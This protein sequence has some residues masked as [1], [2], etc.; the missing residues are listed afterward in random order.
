MKWSCQSTVFMRVDPVSAQVLKVK[1]GEIHAAHWFLTEHV[2]PPPCAS[3]CALEIMLGRAFGRTEDLD[4]IAIP[5]IMDWPK[6][7]IAAS[8]FGGNEPPGRLFTASH[9][10]VIIDSELMFI[11]GPSNIEESI[12]VSG[13]DGELPSPAGK[14][15]AKEV[16]EELLSLP[17]TEIRFALT[18]ADGVQID[19]QSRIGQL[20][21]ESLA[22][23]E[24]YC[25]R[26]Q[27]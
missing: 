25:S 27:N 7:Y 12:W 2:N 6:S 22:Y 8:L 16:C 5:H 3:G 26:N 4:G 10:F 18:V 20:L 13:A 11:N 21:R 17:E 15:L 24:I 23:A 19:K 14:R 1:A 9:E